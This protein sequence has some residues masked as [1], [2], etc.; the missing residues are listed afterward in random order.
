VIEL[1]DLRVEHIIKELNFMT[2]N[3]K[4][5]PLLLTLSTCALIMATGCDRDRPSILTQGLK[6]EDLKQ[7]DPAATPR[8]S[9]VPTDESVQKPRY[10]GL[11]DEESAEA[12]ELGAEFKK[13]DSTC[14]YSASGAK[15][16]V[17]RYH[18][19]VCGYVRELGPQGSMDSIDVPVAEYDRARTKCLEKSKELLAQFLVN[20]SFS[21]WGNVEEVNQGFL[22]ISRRLIGEEK[23]P[24][25]EKLGISGRDV[26]DRRQEKAAYEGRTFGHS[27]MTIWPVRKDGKYHIGW[28]LNSLD[29]RSAG[30]GS[31][32]D[33]LSLSLTFVPK[34]D[35]CS[36]EYATGSYRIENNYD[37]LHVGNGTMRWPIKLSIEGVA[38]GSRR[39]V[40]STY[41]LSGRARNT[42][43]L[44]HDLTKSLWDSL[45][46]LMRQGK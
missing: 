36:L 1:F 45:A 9:S 46:E 16:G 24:P 19:V 18:G 5:K 44:F 31:V 40:T 28:S 10:S 42:P 26:K 7:V 6:T 34:D 15:N 4:Y 32:G 35:G 30:S 17:D 3:N 38:M 2:T 20:Y 37:V 27:R 14:E 22:T 43:Y 8:P 23:L 12:D 21:H 11:T 33:E 41:E 29:A 13:I 25:G 39:S